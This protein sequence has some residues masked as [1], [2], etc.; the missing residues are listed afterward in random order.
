MRI[1]RF[2]WFAW[3]LLTSAVAAGCESQEA[4]PPATST[5][6]ATAAAKP[7]AK[8]TATATA[9]ATA[10]TTAAA[11]VELVEKDLSAAGAAFTG[12]VAKGPAD[13]TVME[14]MGGARI[15][16]KKVSGPGSFDVDFKM[17]KQDL[18]KHKADLEKGAKTAKSTVTF[19][20]ETADTLVWT[21][22]VGGTKSYDFLLLQKSSD[23]DVTCYTVT[24]RESEAELKALQDACKT[25]EKK[26]EAPKA[27]ATAK[28][29]A[30][31]KVGAPSAKTGAP[32][33]KIAAPPGK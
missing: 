7:T 26:G 11:A 6:A 2:S 15:A 1:S 8:P 13:A 4:A 32:P 31:A 20:T 28:S 9:I 27:D 18:K 22:D 29:D 23:K 19:T 14:D 12:W 25:L 30:T 17:G 24:S 10:T 3:A 33:A 21:T 5:A 16:T